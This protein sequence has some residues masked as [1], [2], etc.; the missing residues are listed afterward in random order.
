MYALMLGAPVVAGKILQ[1]VRDSGAKRRHAPTEARGKAEGNTDS[2]LGWEP[3]Q[4][5]MARQTTFCRQTVK[6][7]EQAP[8]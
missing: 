8:I 4:K 3:K 7:G 2:I 1:P 5:L 6:A